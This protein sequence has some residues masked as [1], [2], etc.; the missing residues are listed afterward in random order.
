MRCTAGSFT[1]TNASATCEACA[2]GSFTDQTGSSTCQLCDVG[3]YSNFIN[4]TRPSCTPANP[5]YYAQASSDTSLPCEPGA[6]QPAAGRSFCS[7]CDAGSFQSLP[8]QTACGAVSPGYFSLEG[9]SSPTPCRAGSYNPY[10]SRSSCLTCPF[11]TFSTL[12]AQSAYPCTPCGAGTFGNGTGLSSFDQCEPCAAG[13]SSATAGASLCPLCDPGKYQPSQGKFTC[14][15]CPANTYLT[16]TGATSQ[17]D[18]AQCPPQTPY[19]LPASTTPQACTPLPCASG[20]YASSNAS[21]TCDRECPK[22]TY[23]LNSRSFP[24][25]PGTFAPD[26]GSTSCTLCGPGKFSLVLGANESSSCA[27]CPAGTFGIYTGQAPTSCLSCPPG[28]ANNRTGSSSAEDCA[29]CPPGRASSAAGSVACPLC[30]IGTFQP[31]QG[32]AQCRSCRSG[33]YQGETGA[34]DESSCV[35]CPAGTVS[36]AGSGATSSCV[37]LLCPEGRFGSD[38]AGVCPLGSFCSG[39]S[40]SQLCRPGSYSD[41]MGSSS[42]TL[43]PAGRHSTTSGAASADSCVACSPGTWGNST[44]ASSCAMCPFGTASSTAGSVTLDDCQA[45]VSL[46]NRSDASTSDMCIGAIP[47]HVEPS[48]LMP[49]TRALLQQQSS[50]PNYA[51]AQIPVR[52]SSSL[53]EAAFGPD[54]FLS[55]AASAAASASDPTAASISDVAL[56]VCIAVLVVCATLPLLAYRRIPSA[57]ARRLDQFALQR[58]VDDGASPQKRPT[59]WG[60]AISWSFVP[61]AILVGVVLGSASNA[62]VTKALLPASSSS[63]EARGCIQ[64]TLRAFGQAAADSSFICTAA[65]NASVPLPLASGFSAAPR[66]RSVLSSSACSLAVDCGDC[67]LH[68]VGNWS[69]V[70]PWSYQL[71]E[72]EVWV[73]GAESGAASRLYGVL[74]PMASTQV[75]DRQGELQFSLLQSFYTDERRTSSGARASASASDSSGELDPSRLYESQSGFEVAYQFYQTIEAADSRR[76]TV[77]STSTLSFI[78]NPSDLVYQTSVSDKASQAQLLFSILASI[79]SLFSL[80]AILFRLSERT[81]SKLGVSPVDAVHTFATDS[82]KKNRG[83]LDSGSAS[84]HPGSSSAQKGPGDDDEH[85]AGLEASPLASIQLQEIVR[86]GGVAPAPGPVDPADPPML[87]AEQIRSD[88]TVAA[89]L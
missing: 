58:H 22:G 72:Y 27:E 8:A 66:V 25:L 29:P 62:L 79:V 19:S 61:I 31:E 54:P 71:I 59:K 51:S 17:A 69:I 5:G 9:A 73:T 53:R 76:L 67:S 36:P 7:L 55:R 44:G 65:Q 63:R 50:R 85:F 64:L 80:F 26:T 41:A 10:P 60:S 57:L 33:T 24:C 21:S 84:D 77:A 40:S 20:W 78:F 38:C 18:C 75:L 45:C 23:C 81:M 88:D 46:A 4:G 86:S 32:Q 28:T 3:S 37:A 89:A 13:S 82:W 16:T 15:D 42:C 48:D 1:A 6:Y 56:V 52:G 35:A 2:S 83:Q 14:F 87:D 43:C 47:L 30:P 39:A 11:G 34:I 74:A 68:G 12:S 70:L 49:M